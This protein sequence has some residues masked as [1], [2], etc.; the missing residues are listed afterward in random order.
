VGYIHLNPFRAGIVETV[1]ALRTYP[2]TGHCALM[3][4]KDIL[5]QDTANVLALFGKTV[6]DARKSYADYV[7]KC[8]GAGRRPELTGGGLIRSAGGWRAIREAYEAGIRLTSDERILGS[9][10][11]VEKTLA[12]AGEDY[13]RRMRLKASGIDLDLVMDVVATH[14][15]VD[16][17]ELCGTSRRHEICRARALI[18]YL[19]V[20]EL[21]ISGAEVARRMNTDRSSV[22]RALGRVQADPAL[23]DWIDALL[24]QLYPEG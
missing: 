22:S 18:S 1:Q 11:F 24:H 6:T 9:S 2:F 15:G 17:A 20:R 10:S 5:W 23:K 16:K 8:A 21:R 3:G 13:D 4:K 7:S 12:Y 19:A 14:L